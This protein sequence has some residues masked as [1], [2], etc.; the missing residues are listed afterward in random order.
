[1]IRI[2]CD[3]ERTKGI[4]LLTA[5]IPI[6]LCLWYMAMMA[7]GK[8]KRYFM[9][10]IRV[11]VEKNVTLFT[12]DNIDIRWPEPPRTNII[13]FQKVDSEMKNYMFHWGH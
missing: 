12:N 1:M 11:I 7:V 4:S 2:G 5:V 8:E 3:A 10:L 6:Y 13:S 9:K